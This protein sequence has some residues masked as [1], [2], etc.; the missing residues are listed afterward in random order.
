ML[1]KLKQDEFAVRYLT[2]YFKDDGIPDNLMNDLMRFLE[3]QEQIVS[4]DERYYWYGKN[5]R[6]AVRKLQDGTGEDFEIVEAKDVLCL[7]RKLVIPFLEKLDR[8]D[9]TKR[10]ENKRVWKY[11]N[12]KHK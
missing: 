5:F 9:L 12:R 2:D 4:L 10:V 8:L 3:D 11:P 1:Q 6:E 7:S